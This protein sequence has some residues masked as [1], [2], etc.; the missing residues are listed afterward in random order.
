ML[1]DHLEESASA[2]IGN[3]TVHIVVNLEILNFSV[4]ATLQPRGKF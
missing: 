4:D 2:Q 3:V 1:V